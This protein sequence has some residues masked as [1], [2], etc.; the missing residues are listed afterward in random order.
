MHMTGSN[1]VPNGHDLDFLRGSHPSVLIP[2]GQG[3]LYRPGH[4]DRWE[5][6]RRRP[7]EKWEFSNNIALDNPFLDDPKLIDPA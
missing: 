7:E 1:G 4:S 6:A 3:H 2:R 5:V